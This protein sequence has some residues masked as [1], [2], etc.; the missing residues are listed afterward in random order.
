MDDALI[1][2]LRSALAKVDAKLVVRAEGDVA[3]SIAVQQVRCCPM[4]YVLVP[5][6]RHSL[7]PSHPRSLFIHL[8]QECANDAEVVL[9]SGQV[10]SPTPT[11]PHSLSL[12]CAFPVCM[13]FR[14][15]YTSH[16]HTHTHTHTQTHTHT[17]TH[18]H[19]L[20]AAPATTVPLRLV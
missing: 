16:T 7:S 2:L 14:I 10:R 17:H 11:H 8:L 12:C 13:T 3:L 1:D 19:T 4:S 5:S 6:I 15:K 9:A 20:P 18:T